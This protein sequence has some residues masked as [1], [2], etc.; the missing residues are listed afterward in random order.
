MPWSVPTRLDQRLPVPLLLVGALDDYRAKLGE[1]A[2]TSAVAGPK[3]LLPAWQTNA[4]SDAMQSYMDSLGGSVTPQQAVAGSPSPN[5]KSWY[6]GQDLSSTE[7]GWNTEFQQA[8]QFGLDDAYKRGALPDYFTQDNANG[9]VTWDNAKGAG[10][11]GDG[12]GYKFGDVVV[13][14]KWAGNVYQD[15]DRHTA[16]V[17]MGDLMIQTADGKARL[18]GVT[19]GGRRVDLDW[20]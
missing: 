6:T 15:F 7:N 16:N 19:A 12:S 13:N 1:A 3:G 11:K 2:P 17:M 14:G 10:E 8:Y 18:K 20:F 9:V 5:F 4:G